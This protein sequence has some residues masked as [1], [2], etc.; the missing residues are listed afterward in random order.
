MDGEL[1][2]AVRPLVDATTILIVSADP[3]RRAALGGV[4]AEAGYL[5]EFSDTVAGVRNGMISA[6]PALIILEGRLS[7]RD[8]SAVCRDLQ[9]QTVCPFLVVDHGNDVID[10]VI[11]LELGADDYLAHPIHERELLARVRA[12]LRRNRSVVQTVHAD[13]RKRWRLSLVT[14]QLVG[15]G[16]ARPVTLTPAEHRLLAAFLQRPG[17]PLSCVEVPLQGAPLD[18]TTRQFRT[19]VLRLRRKLAA[20]GFADDVIRSLRSTGYVFDSGVAAAGIVAA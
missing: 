19:Y 7:G 4:L 10:R 13:S 16:D 14:R 5:C 17:L 15:P 1:Y 11:A 12:L 6:P 8:A 3:L 9:S 20:A 2:R 18:Y